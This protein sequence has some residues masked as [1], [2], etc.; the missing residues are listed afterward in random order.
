MQIAF[1]LAMLFL[2]VAIGIWDIY[3]TA[4]EQPEAMVSRLLYSWSILYPILPFMIGVVIGHVFWPTL[5]V[6]R[7]IHVP[8]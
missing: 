6:V 5:I 7:P 8:Q 3:A 1:S 2:A 4:T